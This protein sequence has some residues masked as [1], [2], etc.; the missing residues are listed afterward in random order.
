V[1]ELRQLRLV[2]FLE[3]LSFVLLLFVAMPLKYVWELPLA[4]RIVGSLHGFLF[5][6]FLVALLRAAIERDWPLRR[7]ATAFVASIVPFGTFFFDGS[8]R[9]EIASVSSAVE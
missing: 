4:V 2:A 1:N 8:L 7:S 3:G 9:T 5:L 6:V